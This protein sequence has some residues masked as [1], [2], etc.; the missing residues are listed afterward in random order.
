MKGMADSRC[1]LF[2]SFHNGEPC[3]LPFTFAIISIRGFYFSPKLW[4]R[5]QVSSPRP[6]S[7]QFSP[8]PNSSSFLH[9]QTRKHQKVISKKG[10]AVFPFKVHYVLFGCSSNSITKPVLP[11]KSL[12]LLCFLVN[13]IGSWVWE[14]SNRAFSKAQ[15]CLVAVNSGLARTDRKGLSLMDPLTPL[16]SWRFQRRPS[17]KTELPRSEWKWRRRDY[18]ASSWLFFFFSLNIC[19]RLTLLLHPVLPQSYTGSSVFRIL[20]T[21]SEIETS[22]VG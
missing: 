17:K 19:R 6:Q 1:C 16:S 8:A 21:R 18:L 11:L 3:I 15:I 2:H 9:N 12:L 7:P 13:N 14:M 4:R 5:S 20:V 22:S 10:V